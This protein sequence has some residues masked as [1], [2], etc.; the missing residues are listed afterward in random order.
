MTREMPL[1]RIRAV[2][3]RGQPA[4]PFSPLTPYEPVPTGGDFFYTYGPRPGRDRAESMGDRVDA[5]RVRGAD[6]VRRRIA[7]PVPRL[8]RRLAG[9]RS[10]VRRTADRVRRPH[11][12]DS[13]RRVRHVRRRDDRDVQAPA[14]R[15]RLR[16][17]VR[18]APWTSSGDRRRAVRSSRTATSTS[19]TSSSRRASR[20]SERHGRFSIGYPRARRR[21]RDQRANRDHETAGCRSPACVHAGRLR[22]RRHADRRVPRQRQVPHA[23]T[24]SARMEI[25]DGVAYGEPFE[26]VTAR[27][28]SRGRRRAAREHPAR[29]GRRSRHRR[30][31]R[32]LERHLLVQLRRARDSCRVARGGEELA[33]S[34]RRASSTSRPAAAERSTR[35]ATTFAERC[36]T[37]SSPTKASARS[38]A[39]LSIDNELMTVRLEAASPRLA[40]SAS[41]RI[42]LTPELDAELTISVSDTS[43]DP[44]RARVPAAAVSRTRPRW[45]AARCAWSA[46]SPTSITCS[47]TRRSNGSTCGSSTTRCATR[48]R[49]TS[50]SIVT[51]CASPTC[52]SS[53]RTRSSTCPASSTSTTHGSRCAPRGDANLGRAAGLRRR[54]AQ[55]GHGGALGHARRAARGS[56]RQRHD[57][58]QNGRIRHFAL[59]HALENISGPLRFDTRGVTLDGLTGRLGGGDVTFGGRIDKQGYLPGRIDITMTGTG[60][61]LR[62]SRGHAVA[63]GCAT[64]RCRARC[65]RRRCRVA[66]R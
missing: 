37:S 20:V 24:A 12:R 60:M 27:R 59:P 52:A 18:C 63:R 35:R 53:G 47:W 39:N 9:E 65:R 51:P 33:A 10:R 15:R 29:Q 26:S 2:E 66:S 25:A 31:L 28:P 61:R 64:L 40:V 5:R 62:L 22:P 46:S 57:D 23:R 4:G 49:S 36:A 30:R 6:G 50:R 19:P 32:R 58:D 45:R 8:E 55:L 48:G 13:D 3:Q 16:R 44:V 7:D 38:S 11:A 43:L 42:A 54:R 56:A 1:E 17:R 34:D 14:D 41:G 21:R